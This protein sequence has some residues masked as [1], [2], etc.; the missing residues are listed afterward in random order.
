M[1]VLYTVNN[2]GT[3]YSIHSV[4]SIKS[5]LWVVYTEH[6]V[7]SVYSTHSGHCIQY[8]QWVQSVYCGMGV[9]DT[10]PP[11]AVRLWEHWWQTNFYCIRR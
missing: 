6:T 7:G 9:H 1:W 8:T 3:V 2:V 10:I 11:V 4:Y 5:T